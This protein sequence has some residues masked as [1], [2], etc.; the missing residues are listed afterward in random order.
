MRKNKQRPAASPK[1]EYKASGYSEEESKTIVA[2][3][4]KLARHFK[5]DNVEQLPP[6]DVFAVIRDDERHPLR[7]FFDWD[8]K[9]AAEAYWISKTRELIR[10][11]KLVRL[12]LPPLGTP[13]MQIVKLDPSRMKSR[14]AYVSNGRS[15]SDPRKS[16]DPEFQRQISIQ[17]GAVRNAIAR[18]GHIT[19]CR[20]G[21]GVW[22]ELSAL[23]A[24]LRE[25]IGAYEARDI[26]HA[27]E[28]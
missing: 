23:V 1:Y 11:V 5:V 10:C 28:D 2:E 19:D 27:A 21:R 16:N 3:L 25:A 24:S 22:P 12:D 4:D 13:E 7:K 20:D 14:P 15:Y 9:K 26:G 17:Y 6:R 8:A 18:L